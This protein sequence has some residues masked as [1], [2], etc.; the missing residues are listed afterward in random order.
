MSQAIPLQARLHGLAV[1]VAEFEAPDFSFGDW[2][3]G[4]LKSDNVR[5]MPFYAYSPTAGRFFRACHDLGW[6]R[7]D[8]NW[9]A[10]SNTPESQR[11]LYEAGGVEEASVEDLERLLT[12]CI[13]SARF[14]EGS[15]AGAH[16]SGLL[17]RILRRA[18]ELERG[19]GSA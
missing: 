18:A 13:R 12:M 16:K 19:L 5:T 7:S 17:L 14:S 1:F 3:G 10:W 4:E 6:V 9:V 8:V 11:L 2:A 15:L